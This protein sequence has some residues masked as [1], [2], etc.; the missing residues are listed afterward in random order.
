MAGPPSFLAPQLLRSLT[1]LLLLPAPSE[2]AFGSAQVADK[3]DPDIVKQFLKTTRRSYAL[4][5]AAKHG[6][7]L[8]VLLTKQG[9][10]ACQNLRQAVNRGTEMRGLLS[11]F[12]VCHAEGKFA[13]EWF[14][15]G[16]EGYVP[17]TLFFAPG[18]S[19][20][21]PIHVSA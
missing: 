6:K 3:F 18:E 5:R 8:M 12:V 7:P 1:V 11:D 16:Q 9:C 14:E 2:G 4:R 15:K 17:Q 10:G 20:P 13:A 21:L 19:K